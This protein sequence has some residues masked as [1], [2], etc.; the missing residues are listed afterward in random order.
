M[1]NTVTCTELCIGYYS[2]LHDDTETMAAIIMFRA[3]G[4]RILQSYAYSVR[5][6][7]LLELKVMIIEQ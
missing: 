6:S 4:Q 3:C 1:I 7:K 5:N 2:L